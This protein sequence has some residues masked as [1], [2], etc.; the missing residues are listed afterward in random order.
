MR[1]QQEKYVVYNDSQSAIHLSKN[2]HS[3]LDWSILML[4]IIGFDGLNSKQL[5]LE[6]VQTSENGSNMLTKCLRKEKLKACRQR[7]SL[8]DWHEAKGEICWVPHVTEPN[9]AKPITLKF[10]KRKGDKKEEV[11]GSIKR[12]N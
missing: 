11:S 9:E 6:K 1:L 8:V 7:A 3:I 10:K 5:Y 12:E 4:G 2:L